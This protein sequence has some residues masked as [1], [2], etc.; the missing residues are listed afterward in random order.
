MGARFSLDLSVW[1]TFIPLQTSWR[2]KLSNRL[3]R[4]NR[5]TYF[6][7]VRRFE[8]PSTPSPKNSAGISLCS[9][10][11]QNAETDEVGVA[12]SIRQIFGLAPDRGWLSP[13]VCTLASFS[14]TPLVE[15]GR[16]LVTFE[17]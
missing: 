1:H 8:A 2:L 11:R 7:T 4:M 15:H 6:I 16:S 14:P 9:V 5:S 10:A 13:A 12:W 17:D 3:M